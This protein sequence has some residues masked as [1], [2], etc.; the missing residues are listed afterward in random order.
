MGHLQVKAK[1]VED[2]QD[3]IQLGGRLAA[4][5]VHNEAKPNTRSGCQ[6]RLSEA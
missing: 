1:D 2:G 5:K 4:F 6:V 3:P